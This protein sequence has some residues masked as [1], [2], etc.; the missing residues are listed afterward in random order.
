MTRRELAKISHNRRPIGFE[1]N[2]AVPSLTTRLFDKNLVDR[3]RP[4]SQA[5]RQHSRQT[6]G[7][8]GITLAGV[9]TGARS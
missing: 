4:A 8:A 3:T 2:Q 9:L 1:E 6:T 7:C 5:G